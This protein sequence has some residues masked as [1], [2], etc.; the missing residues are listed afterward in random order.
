MAE[1]SRPFVND[2]LKPVIPADRAGL[3][4][5]LAARGNVTPAVAFQR[6]D[7]AVKEISTL[8]AIIGRMLETQPTEAV[9]RSSDIDL[10][11]KHLFLV[12]VKSR[13]SAHLFANPPD[14]FNPRTTRLS[15]AM[16]TESLIR[17]LS[18]VPMSNILS[19]GETP[20]IRRLTSVGSVC[21]EFQPLCFSLLTR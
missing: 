14:G 5:Q 20:E 1:Y 18:N 15:V 9:R 11:V 6:F 17:H 13:V 8:G 3:I 4:E 19:T 12:L 21:T 16:T 2:L 7:M 10:A